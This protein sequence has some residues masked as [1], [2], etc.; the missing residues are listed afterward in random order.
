VL[1][2]YMVLDSY[3]VLNRLYVAG[4]TKEHSKFE[5]ILY[6]TNQWLVYTHVTYSELIRSIDHY[7]RLKVAFCTQC[8]YP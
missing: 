1:D 4:A 8:G 5:T 3:T 7:N 2:S 6:I